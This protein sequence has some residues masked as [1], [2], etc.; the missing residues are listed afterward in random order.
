MTEQE[1]REAV[2]PAG[3]A[4]ESAVP[5]LARHA[6]LGTMQSSHTSPVF[7]GRSAELT[8][9]GEALSR[10]NAGEP[11]ALFVGGEAGV[12]KTRL[13]QEF[14]GRA[15]AGGAV[16]ALGGCV[17]IGADALPYHPVST[18]LRSLRRQLGEELDAAVAGQEGE[19]ARL[20]PELGEMDRGHLET[21]G[22]AR[23]FELTA[24]LLERLA[25]DRTLVLVLEDL[26][27]ADRSTR[28]LLSYLLRA[29]TDSR[30]LI[31]ATFRA[32]DL[33]RRHPLRPALAEYE[34]LRTVTRVDLLRFDRAEVRR[35]LAAIRGEAPPEQ[36]LDR[37]F[38][39][40]EGNAFFVEELACSILDGSPGGISDSL[41]DLLLVRV[42]ALPDEAQ[43]VVRIAAEGGSE[44]EFRLLATVTG[45]TEDELIEILRTVVGAAVLQPCDD[46]E[47]FRFRHALMREAVAGDLLP[48]ERS[49]LNR[50]Y[51]EALE[52]DPTL[53]R[54]AELTGR[55][56]G[57]WFG[58]RDAARALPAAIAA[59]AA[60]RGR[61]A[62]AEQHQLLERA[63]ELWDDAPEE[64]RRRT[65]RQGV[66][67]GLGLAFSPDVTGDFVD[68][69]AAVAVAARLAGERERALALCKRALRT[70][71]GDPSSDAS[72]RT[73]AGDPLRAAW[74]W[75]ERH[76]LLRA[77][78]RSD[79]WDEIAHA[80][81]LV[82]GL[83]P[84]VVHAEVLMNAAYWWAVHQP[85]PTALKTAQQA[86]E[87]C[88]LTGAEIA[89]LAAQ[90]TL[91]W[92]IMD[93][94]DL[95]EGLALARD[96]C[97]RELTP[98]NTDVVLRGYGN[99]ATALHGIG[100]FG[101][102]VEVAEKGSGLADRH[103][104]PDIAS[105]VDGNLAESLTQLGRWS[106][107][108]AVLARAVGRRGVSART[109]GQVAE[110]RAELTLARGAYEETRRVLD[111][112]GGWTSGPYPE[113][114]HTL[115]VARFAIALAAAD[116][117]ILDVRSLLAAEVGDGI[118]SGHQR[119]G[120]PLL[121]EAAAAE[122][123]ARGQAVAE[124]GRA[125]A[126]ARIRE[127]MRGQPDF[128]PLWAA[129]ALMIEA[130]LVTAEDGDATAPWTEAVAAVEQLQTPVLLA[131]ARLRLAEALITHGGGGARET[132]GELLR[133]AETVAR[134]LGAAPLEAEI[135][136]LAGR[137]RIPLRQA[138]GEA[139]PPPAAALGLTARERDVLRLVAAGRSN[140][141]IAEELFI[142]P[143]T[144]SVHVSNILAKL[145]A[146]GRG[147]AAAIAHRLGVFDE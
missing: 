32:D 137:A 114:Q 138:D 68:L 81:E 116:G 98:G 144:A 79:G 19:L 9:L 39:R 22:R 74:F 1:P 121:Y 12:G 129:Q 67:D 65:M 31:V 61:H 49:R 117:R 87:I 115:T 36:V 131:G 101:E 70:L 50:R 63:L 62:F 5:P 55:L 60:A 10:A 16:V 147:E 75:T 14:L 51:A 80:Q 8:A 125:A 90:Q 146:S 136:T 47:S 3:D 46:G 84:S 124:P 119:Y 30:M 44:V 40:S 57:Y 122:A 59:A 69:L 2:H 17:E 20:L 106:E 97:E 77:L 111:E 66:E 128:V 132:A 86:V 113:P 142:S 135:G 130:E 89:G 48:G 99:V 34:R 134:E 58:A 45:R 145:G 103:G 76:R 18:A 25:A 123:R 71:E 100:R 93:T 21:D 96:V 141:L 104:L 78:S 42:E 13:I 24:R 133:Q 27:W 120:W 52:A 11:R 7:V 64:L 88:R 94:G 6:M 54:P 29:L 83:P 26:H 140:R 139:A 112:S 107:A 95:E 110:Q 35:Q 82:Q 43:R 118:P 105:F 73:A 28:E 126:V 143:K 108:D 33:H 23:L 15:A 38:D 56:A 41:R 72:G 109:W 37:I 85:G 53:V 127:A 102:A 4:A 91:A 92:L